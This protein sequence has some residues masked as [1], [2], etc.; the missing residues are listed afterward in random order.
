MN[1]RHQKPAH[2]VGFELR[3]ACRIRKRPFQITTRVADAIRDDR[4]VGLACGMGVMLNRASF[5]RWI[6]DSIARLLRL[7]FGI[8]PRSSTAETGLSESAAPVVQQ[9]IFRVQKE[10]AYDPPSSLRPPTLE[11]R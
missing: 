8:T 6:P 3:R 2:T 9:E 10:V 4:E 1:H 7:F 5:T 11:Q